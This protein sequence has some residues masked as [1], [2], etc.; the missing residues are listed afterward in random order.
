MKIKFVKRANMWC[1]TYFEDGKQNQKWFITEEEA[2][3]FV[4]SYK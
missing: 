1:V 2:Q 4:N 3:Q